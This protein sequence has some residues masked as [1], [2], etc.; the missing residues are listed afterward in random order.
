MKLIT[1]TTDPVA[2]KSDADIRYRS[3]PKIEKYIIFY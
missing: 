1:A 2:I 3:V